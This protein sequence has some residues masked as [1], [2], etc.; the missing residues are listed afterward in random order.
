[1]ENLLF[2]RMLAGFEP[3][4]QNVKVLHFVHCCQEERKT[5]LV[6]DSRGSHFWLGYQVLILFPKKGNN[7]CSEET[8][9]F[10]VKIDGSEILAP[11]ILRD[12]S[13]LTHQVDCKCCHLAEP[14]KDSQYLSVALN[15]LQG[16]WFIG[17]INKEN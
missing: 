13:L 17:F 1:M 6:K 14:N 15:F 9:D 2:S 16:H 10:Q 7:F 11:L 4:L 5:F 8:G 3:L 12:P